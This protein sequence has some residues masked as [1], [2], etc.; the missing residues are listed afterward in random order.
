MDP[1]HDRAI[2]SLVGLAIGD[3][4]GASLKGMR[5]DQ[6]P[7][8]QDLIGGGPFALPPGA[9]TDDTAMAL[10]LAESLKAEAEFSPQDYMERLRSWWREGA[11][12]A[13]GTAIDVNPI[14]RAAL[15]RFEA[16]GDPLAGSEKPT[17]AGSGAISR[18][19]PIAIR[20]H[21]APERAAQ[22]A[23][24]QSRTTHAAPACL[25]AAE[26]LA[27]VLSAAIAGAG[28]AAMLQP[29]RPGWLAE[30]IHIAA[31]RW[32][33]KQRSQIRTS[34]YVVDTLEAAFWC[35][36]RSEDARSA[37]LMA[38]NLAGEADA[39]AA[40]AGQLAGSI[41]GASAFPM[42]WREKIV[43][44]ERMVALASELCDLA[45]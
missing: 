17:T 34:G 15:E 38:A 37:V 29:A 45:K 6:R 28:K 41:W 7:P 26:L 21:G 20:W 14:V 40:V 2:G 30:I 44:H 24:L 13:T 11:Y 5:R 1:R 19:A 8:L 10:A 35:V 43:A 39:V 16:S 18:L 31:G 42:A 9:W 3:A 23:R 22:F 4:L 25:D 32:R 33:D 12:S 27:R 36:A